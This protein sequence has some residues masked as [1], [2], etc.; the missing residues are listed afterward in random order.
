M[1]FTSYRQLT[2][3]HDLVRPT[4][5]RAHRFVLRHGDGMGRAQ[6]LELFKRVGNGVL[7]GTSSFWEGV[8]VPGDALRHVIITKLPFEVPNHPVVEARHADIKRRGGN[9]FMERTVPEAIIRLKQGFGR[10][11]RSR[12]DTGTVVIS[13]HRVLTAAYGRYF[14]RALPPCATELFQLEHYLAKVAEG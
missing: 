13:D 2:A 7:F 12:L 9:P 4:L 1:L 3:V 11:I 8:D 6:M 10:L 14:L 5:D